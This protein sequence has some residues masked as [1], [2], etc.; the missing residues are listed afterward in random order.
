MKIYK[1][2]LYFIFVVFVAVV[3]AIALSSLPNEFFRDRGNYIIYASDTDNIISRYTGLSLFSN[4]P[5]F[6]LINKFSSLFLSPELVPKLFVFFISFTICF[7]ILYKS[8]NFII[9]LLGLIA[10]LLLPQGFHLQFVILRQG[11]ATCILLWITYFFWSKKYY[12]FYVFLI[13]FIHSGVFI[14]FAFL[15]L[16]KL[17]LSFISK[18]I[19]Y[20]ILFLL[21]FSI[22]VSF[23]IMPLAEILTMRQAKE[24]VADN[25][26]ISGGNFILYGF[27]LI[28]LLTQKKEIH[29]LDG[30]YNI[31]I[32][33]LSIYIGM[34]FFTQLSGR[35]ISSFIPFIICTLCYF[36]NARAYVLL[37]LIIVIN[38]IIFINTIVNNSLTNEG[39]RML[40]G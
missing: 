14:I 10:I 12:L 38:S 2:S 5:L 11:I 15:V 24:H 27:I 28:A 13:G 39:V 29:R 22:L 36:G 23:F 3:Y 37:I 4:E 31:A 34:Y 17:F 1:S 35:L 32:I 21:A 16:D 40:I 20:R 30:I 6:L 26:T 19:T 25:I 33:G 9:G 7:F 18:K 8:E